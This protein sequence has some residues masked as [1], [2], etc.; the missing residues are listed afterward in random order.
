MLTDEQIRE[1]AK[2]YAEQ[3]YAQSD[4]DNRV[5][6]EEQ[7]DFMAR[8]YEAFLCHLLRDHYIVSN[9]VLQELQKCPERL[10]GNG[11]FG[12]KILVKLFSLASMFGK[13]GEG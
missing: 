12:L 7:I 1:I 5:E 6:R 3:E 11:D 8:S 10:E 4:Y 9:S 2:K 13:E